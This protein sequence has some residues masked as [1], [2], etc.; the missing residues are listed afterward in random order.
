MVADVPS[1]CRYNLMLPGDPHLHT[2]L[3]TLAV[4]MAMMYRNT[5][6]DAD[7]EDRLKIN[8]TLL[9]SIQSCTGKE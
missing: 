7:K 3:P 9:L 2:V 8:I 5:L 1:L 6:V 4:T